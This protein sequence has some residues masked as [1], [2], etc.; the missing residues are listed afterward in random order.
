[1]E[2]SIFTSLTVLSQ[3]SSDEGSSVADPAT[4]GLSVTMS[5]GDMT[6]PEATV[7]RNVQ[8]KGGRQFEDCLGVCW[9]STRC[10]VKLLA[11]GVS[12]AT[13]WDFS[14]QE[15]ME[16]GRRVVTLLRAFNMRHGHTAEMDAPSP[17]YG[18]TPVD[19]PAQGKSIMPHWNE[20]RSKYYEGM[21]WDKETGKPTPDTLRQLGLGYA[22]PELWER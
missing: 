5:P 9:I 13:G 19:G 3:M 8:F 16:V 2:L 4:F 7:D 18:S 11:Q 1:M 21:G 12:A 17:R 22:I 10:H 20:M 14:P 6:S 15:A